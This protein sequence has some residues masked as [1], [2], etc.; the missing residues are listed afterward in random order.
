M[1]PSRLT[2][3]SARSRAF[4]WRFSNFAK[5]YPFAISSVFMGARYLIGDVIAQQSNTHWD[6][7]R[8]TT[9]FVFGIVNGYAW[10][11]VINQ[12]YPFLMRAL[13]LKNRLWMI[14]LEGTINIP[15]IYYPMFYITQDF[16]VNN[17]FSVSQAWS[18]YIKNFQGDWVAWSKF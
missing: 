16:I 18:L 3:W 2:H 12:L 6:R 15:F 13:T 14:V 17:G 11:R 8:S 7:R 5:K 4:V 9:F 1:S 10:G